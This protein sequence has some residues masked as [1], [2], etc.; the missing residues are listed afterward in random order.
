[1]VAWVAWT[2]VS[3]AVE[4]AYLFSVGCRNGAIVPWI[5]GRAQT[6]RV[7]ALELVGELTAEGLRELTCTP[8]LQAR[9]SRTYFK[10]GTEFDLLSSEA[11]QSSAVGSFKVLARE[12]GARNS[13]CGLVGWGEDVLVSGSRPAERYVAVPHG[14]PAMAPVN[15]IPREPLNTR[16]A[17][18]L[19]QRWLRL[20]PEAQRSPL[21]ISAAHLVGSGK[22]SLRVI[23]V[24]GGEP[25]P[26]GR[27]PLEGLL[28]T[29]SAGQHIVDVVV[30]PTNDIK[31]TRMHFLDAVDVAGDG[32]TEILLFERYRDGSGDY[33]IVTEAEGGWKVAMRTGDLQRRRYQKPPGGS[34]FQ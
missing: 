30:E 27:F 4:P 16:K 21:Q 9:L 5:E 7:C 15:V 1:M 19:A 28:I 10:K 31:T 6:A 32:H 13:A 23:E 12:D 26:S 14:N 20:R 11:Q 17:T 33:V 8:K 34:A 24:Q 29:D 22:T 18:A 2:P 25:D 3:S